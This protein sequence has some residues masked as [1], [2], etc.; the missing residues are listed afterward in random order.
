MKRPMD[1]TD[2]EWFLEWLKLAQEDLKRDNK[3]PEGYWQC[4]TSGEQV[5]YTWVIE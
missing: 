5:M 3:K 1:L 4:I 2:Y